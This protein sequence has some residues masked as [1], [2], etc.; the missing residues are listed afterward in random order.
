METFALAER[1]ALPLCKRYV[2]RATQDA[3]RKMRAYGRTLEF[4]SKVAQEL[5][6]TNDVAIRARNLQREIVRMGPVYIKMG[7][8]VS[9]RTDIFPQEVTSVFE[10]LQSDVDCMG[11]EQVRRVFR[12]EFDA[13]L[14]DHFEEFSE[15]PVA[16]ASI[17]QVHVG[18]LKDRGGARVAIKVLREDI[19]ER[20]K[21]EVSSIIDI[22][23]LMRLVSGKRNSKNLDDTLMI[24]RQQY[25]NVA[26]ETDL[27][28][29]QRNMR[30]FHE[31]MRSNERIAIPR[32]YGALSGRT[33][34]TM[35]YLPSAKITDQDALGL[36]PIERRELA[37]LLMRTFVS[38]VLQDGYL[39]C[40]P[41]PGNIGYTPDG[42]VVLYDFGLVREFSLDLKT[43]FRKIFM[44]LV[45]RQN[46]EMVDFMLTSGIILANE[47]GART[48]DALTEYERTVITRI[49]GYVYTYLTNMNVLELVR[50]I[51][52][53]PD[54]D[55]NDIPFEFDP[56][57]VYL[58][59]SF[60]TLEGVCKQLYPE[61]S[62]V[63]LI[64]NLFFDFL[65][66]QMIL[67]KATY[68][69]QSSSAMIMGGVGVPAMDA[70]G[71]NARGGR[72]QSSGASANR[73]F[74]SFAKL[75]IEKLNKRVDRNADNVQLFLA[76]SFL[77]DLLLI[78]TGGSG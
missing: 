6:L 74:E 61:F 45:N 73:D 16:A 26:H 75:S 51:E 78:L 76:L 27:G 63:E 13:E 22:L 44:A 9:T 37:T 58:F 12:A 32:S 5:V 30:L 46:N 39:H 60:S 67:D 68:D 65:D 14:E 34:M 4:T 31:I 1:G 38:T 7:Q 56:Q 41:H 11:I 25:D 50:S 3:T 62:Y 43:Y 52:K 48:F 2:K 19:E 20:F 36:D 54:I 15:T 42:R 71:N 35:E 17:A 24:L 72:P 10:D 21:E 64:S 29:E 70:L 47:S 77:L 49:V 8:I 18:T 33:V 23:S 66:L 28:V 69:L 57:L 53:D 59:Q 40:D 55:V